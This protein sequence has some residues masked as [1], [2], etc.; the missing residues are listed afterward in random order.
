MICSV[1]VI[2]R[3]CEAS[4]N[5]RKADLPPSRSSG[6]QGRSA[7]TD[8][9]CVD[10][11]LTKLA[12]AQGR[13]ARAPDLFFFR[14]QRNRLVGPSL[15]D[16]RQAPR[17]GIE[18]E[19]VLVVR[20]RNRRWTLHDMQTKV[21]CVAEDAPHVVAADDHHLE[22][23]LVGNPLSDR[24]GS[25]RGTNLWR[26]DRRRSQT[27]R[28]DARADGSPA[29]SARNVPAFQRSSSVS[30]LSDTQSAA[31]DLIRI[32]SVE[33]PLMLRSG[34]FWIPENER[35]AANDT[36]KCILPFGFP[37]PARPQT[38]GIG[39]AESKVEDGVTVLLGSGAFGHSDGTPTLCRH[40]PRQSSPRRRLANAAASSCCPDA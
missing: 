38:D 10:V 21:E 40:N 35:S 31:G 23:S 33:L 19:F 36:H 20:V 30:R 25:F 39:P 7:S 14:G 34:D 16:I 8:H 5:R 18:L 9:R 28:R 24:Q 17:I 1:A 26:T 13:S 6:G 15:S 32:Y 29:L 3:A 4:R 27:S 2:D 37:K 11:A 22:S 12:T